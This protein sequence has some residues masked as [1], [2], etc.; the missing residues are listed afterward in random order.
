MEEKIDALPPALAGYAGGRLHRLLGVT[1]GVAVAVGNSIG[2]GILKAPGEIAALLPTPDLFLG[3]WVAGGLYALLSALCIAE[4]GTMI[5]RAGGQY[6]FARRAFGDSAGLVVG[7]SDWLSTCGSA[8]A[9]A[10]VIGEYLAPARAVPIAVALTVFFAFLQILGVRVSARVQEWTSLLKTLAF[11]LLIAAC[12]AFAGPVPHSAVAPRA[13]PLLLPLLLAL[14]AVIY[15]YDGWTGVIYFSEEVKDPARDVPRALFSGVA[16][17][18]AIYLLVNLALLRLAPLADYA[19]APLAAG[20]AAAKLFGALGEP[21]L[22]G[23]TIVSMIAAIHA[24]HLM[25]ARV[26]YG[27]A[28][29][30]IFFRKV[31]EVNRVGTPVPAL[32][33]GAGVTTLFI[34]SGTFEQVIA[35]LSFFFV[36]NYSVSFASLFVLRRREPAT[37][38]PFRV[39]LYPLLPAATLAGSLAFLGGSIAGNPRGSLLALGLLAASVPLLLW[40]RR[41]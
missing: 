9:V 39:P 19:G 16:L 10:L 26:L 30:G 5:P 34:L 4:L 20:V 17:I 31:I 8:A 36:A 14:Q 6:A 3:V 27:L 35:V 1:F 25:A 41:R 40:I 38:R 21:V 22:R 18:T 32:L 29:D 15:T 37:A 11:A 28:R 24:Y 2:S 7:I 33:V 23:L 12:F 13:G